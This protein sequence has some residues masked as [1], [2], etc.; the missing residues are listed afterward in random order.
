MHIESKR[1]I[2]SHCTRM[3]VADVVGQEL[4]DIS[5]G[6]ACSRRATS[7]SFDIQDKN[8]PAIGD[9]ERKVSKTPK[10]LQ[11]QKYR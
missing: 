10:S 11:T 3:K 5:D 6:A 4:W 8:T 2:V 7:P 1:L 9:G